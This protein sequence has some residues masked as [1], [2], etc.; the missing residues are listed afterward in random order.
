MSNLLSL[1][2]EIILH[3][4]HHEL[5]VLEEGS[6]SHSHFLGE[7]QDEFL[8]SDHVVLISIH[9]AERP[10]ELTKGNQCVLVPIKHV[11]KTT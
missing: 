1:L 11:V 10:E 9:L 3:L 6:A 5:G 2:L 4:L 7:G 8:F